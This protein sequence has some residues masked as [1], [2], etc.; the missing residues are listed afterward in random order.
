MKTLAI[1][2]ASGFIGRHLVA[3]ALSAGDMRVRV[4]SRRA[5]PAPGMSGDGVTFCTGDLSDSASLAPFLAS[6]DTVIHLAY[7][8]GGRAA[9]VAAADALVAAALQAGV[10][11]FVHC[12]TAVVVGPAAGRAVGDGT[13]PAPTGEY[14]EAKFAIEEALRTS[15]LPGMELAILRPTEVIGP[16]G[17]GLTGMI[18]RVRHGSPALNVARR[19]LLGSRRFNYVAVQNVVSA[20]LLLARTEVSQ[21]GH[22]YNVSDDEDADN[23][24]AAVENTVRAALGRRPARCGGVV[25]TALL[26]VAYRFLPEHSPPD[27][28]YSHAG[29]DRLGYRRVTTLRS[30]IHELVTETQ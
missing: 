20:L 12:S 4:L 24:Y 30:V 18:R 13:R 21:T 29:L 23:T 1:T 19:M 17:A 11:R 3:A 16:G 27:R 28:I 5:A 8:G 22:V 26:S 10:S 7:L 14:Q 6:A 2:G 25:P 15:A 9:N